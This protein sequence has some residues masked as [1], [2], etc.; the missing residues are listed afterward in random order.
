MNA[1]ELLRKFYDATVNDDS[2]CCFGCGCVDLERIREQQ[3]GWSDEAE[4]L[5]RLDKEVAERPPEQFQHTPDCI[6]QA[7]RAL[8][9]S[10]SQ[11]DAG[12]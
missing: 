12:K 3:S 5:A 4:R 7:A 10:P 1:T 11:R 9:E 8:L 6:I 2:M